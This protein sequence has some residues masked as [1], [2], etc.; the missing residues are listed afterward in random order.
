M[1]VQKTARSLRRLP[2]LLARLCMAKKPSLSIPVTRAVFRTDLPPSHCREIG[3]I[4]TRWAYLESYV[5][6]TLQKLSGLS[7]QEGR[8]VLREA[9]LDLRLTIIADVAHLYGLQVDETTLQSMKKAIKDPL[10]KRN[11]MAHGEW[12][13]D[14]NHKKWA[15]T[16][17]KGTWEDQDETERKKTINPEG[18]L[19][20][21][22]AMRETVLQIDALIA[23]A[24]KLHDSF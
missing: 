10:E 11:L 2:Q 4:V 9:R 12:S 22:D 21:V 18:L 20:D 13:Y 6:H 16:Q 23:Q 19:T 3:R 24:K 14:E 1:R 7:E 15:V 8:L 5:L 17:T